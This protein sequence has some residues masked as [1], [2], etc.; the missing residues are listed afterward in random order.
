PFTTFSRETEFHREDTCGGS[1]IVCLTVGALLPHKGIMDVLP[2]VRQ[3]R[4]EGYAVELWHAGASYSGA[5]RDEVERLVEQSGLSDAVRFL[6]YLGHEDLLNAYR[7]ADILVHAARAEGMPRVLAEA[8][9]QSL[10]VVVTEAGGIGEALQHGQNALLV[11]PQDP[12][13]VAAGIRRVVEDRE[14]RR[15]MISNGRAWARA[16]L[17]RDP[18]QQILSVLQI[19]PQ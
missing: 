11:R 15:A 7:Q 12:Q 1:K 13:S 18:V 8:M 9:S 4:A 16:E 6:G 14:L 5:F 10:P 3:L 19:P 17:A 2:A